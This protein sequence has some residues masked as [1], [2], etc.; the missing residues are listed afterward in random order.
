MFA[1]WKYVEENQEDAV[2]VKKETINIE[3]QHSL[4]VFCFQD[5]VLNAG[6]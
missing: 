2:I 1:F 3:F 5:S 6:T 4:C